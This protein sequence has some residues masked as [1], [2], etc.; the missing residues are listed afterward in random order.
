IKD[1]LGWTQS[2]KPLKIRSLVKE[3]LFVAPSM[4][5]LDLIFQMKETGIHMALVVDEYGG[6]DGLVTLSDLMEE[7]IGDI[8]DV[9]D[10]TTPQLQ[11]RPN[12][13]VVADARVSLE[14]AQEKLN[15]EFALEDMPEDIETLGG[16]VITL[17]GRVPV[18][19]E[20]IKHPKGVEFEILEADPRRVKKFCLHGL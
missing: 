3:I 19:G 14:E 7:I 8:Q 13:T 15:Y 12:G 16:L 9:Q 11:K 20:L 1:I 4:R 2:Q 5:T 17:A 10:Q 6:I 18:R